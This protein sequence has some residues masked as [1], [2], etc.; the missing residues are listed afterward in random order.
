MTPRQ[1]EATTSSRWDRLERYARWRKHPPFLESLPGDLLSHIA[2]FLPPADYGSLVTALVGFPPR[3]H[4]LQEIRLVPPEMLASWVHQRVMASLVAYLYS[5]TDL[6]LLHARDC[7][8]VCVFFDWTPFSPHRFGPVAEYRWVPWA[9]PHGRAEVH[10][11]RVE[12][13]LL[14]SCRARRPEAYVSVHTVLHW[15]GAKMRPTPVFTASVP[16]IPYIYF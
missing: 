11:R 6:C 9:A 10:E 7:T 16:T 3:V 2:S 14:R 5:L 15:H 13:A 8:T 12:R 1:K 4:S